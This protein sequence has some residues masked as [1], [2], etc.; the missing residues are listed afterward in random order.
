MTPPDVTKLSLPAATAEL[1]WG[2]RPRAALPGAGGRGAVCPQRAP[3]NR[4]SELGWQRI[5]EPH[6]AE[7]RVC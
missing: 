4:L 7:R 6:R 3:H 1:G 2:A 5:A